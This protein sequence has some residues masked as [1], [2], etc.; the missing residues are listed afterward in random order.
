M[1]GL[2]RK[3]VMNP[4]HF[5]E[6]QGSSEILKNSTEGVTAILQ[7]CFKLENSL[8]E[9]ILLCCSLDESRILPRPENRIL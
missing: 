3:S 4:L 7:N 6:Q 1:T 5:E 2:H 8:S 9:K